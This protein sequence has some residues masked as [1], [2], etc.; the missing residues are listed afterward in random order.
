MRDDLICASEIAEY[1]FC[2]TAWYLQRR[3]VRPSNPKI[4]SGMLYHAEE[5]RKVTAARH[6]ALTASKLRFAG[7]VTVALAL[8]LILL[9]L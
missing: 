8:L 7:M 1:E 9:S 3:G 6:N 4:M 5:H 2:P